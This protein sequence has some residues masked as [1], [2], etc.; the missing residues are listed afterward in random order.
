MSAPPDVVGTVL[1]EP[2]RS[3]HAKSQA[4]YRAKNAEAEREKAR[5]RMRKLRERQSTKPDFYATYVVRALESCPA[6]ADREDSEEFKEFSEYINKVKPVHL[7]VNTEDP[8]EVA[9]F[10]RLIA[11]N[12][13]VETLGPGSEEDIAVFYNLQLRFNRYPEWREELADYRDIIQEYSKEELD[14]MQLVARAKLANKCI[15]L[16]RGGF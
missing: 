13:C 4:K 16:A 12:P 6:N 14:E 9:D 2:Q 1:P 15:I 11:S 10:D 5:L 3:P 8:Q 7:R